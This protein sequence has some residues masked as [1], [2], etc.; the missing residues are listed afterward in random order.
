M[1][2]AVTGL[3]RLPTGQRDN[4]ANLLDVGTGNGRYEVGASGTAD[5]GAGRWGARLSGGYLVRLA[6]LRVLRLTTP[7][8]PYA[9]ASTLANMRLDA[10]DVLS[11]SAR[12]YLPAGAALCAL[13]PRRLLARGEDDASYFRS[14][15]AIPGV[16]A[17]LL[18]VESSRS[19]L[20]LGGGVSYVGRAAHECEP[21]RRCGLPIDA[22]WRYT[23]V[24][25]ATGGRVEKFRST[26]LEIRW[27]QRIWR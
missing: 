15:E 9:L 6:S 1:R 4:P 2:L 25:A 24:T 14:Q 13:R 27:Y 26:R 11:L 5:L 19:A 16:P 3:V 10:G 21:R 20:A 7:G 17:S 22:T 12:P 8:Q 23:I 18:A